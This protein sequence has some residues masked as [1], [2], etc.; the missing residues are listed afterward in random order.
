MPTFV[1]SDSGGED[2]AVQEFNHCHSPADG[3][4]CSDGAGGVGHRV[5]ITSARPGQTGGVYAH[6]NEFTHDLRRVPGVSDV[7]VK[8]G[9]G[10][11]GGGSEPSWIVSYVGNGAARKLLAKTAVRYDQDAVLLMGRCKGKRGC[12]P[13]VDL[14]FE[15]RV[16]EGQMTG[17]NSLL[18]SA[19]FGG[20]TWG[21]VGGKTVLR[22]VS[23]PVWGGKAD[24]HLKTMAQVAGELS[25]HGHPHSYRVRWVKTEV[26]DRDNYAAV[27]KGKA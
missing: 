20:W 13:A 4:F 7:S 11:W 14:R 22:V 12:D 25:A 6:M 15:K 23:V 26:L 21:K 16:T 9:I 1:T 17:I 8:P 18:G 24:R 19:G 27:L 10:A 2:A 5:G 3:K